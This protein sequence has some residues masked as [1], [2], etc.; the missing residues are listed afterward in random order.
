MRPKNGPLPAPWLVVGTALALAAAGPGVLRSRAALPGEPASLAGR[1]LVATEDLR[2]PRFDH[3]VVYMVRHDPTG[4][5]GLVVNRPLGQVP[6]ARLLELF[7]RSDP[8]VAGE[9]R[10]FYGGPVEGARAFVLHTT[11][12]TSPATLVVAGGVAL[13]AHPAVLEAIAH[14]RGPRRSLFAL[15]YAGWAPGQLEGEIRRGS[16]ISVPADE[17]L[18]FDDDADAKWRRAMARRR[19]AI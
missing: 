6:L 13:T 10:V 18:V 14:G 17:A 12:W 5:M 4:A 16:W 11:D 2:D 9:A 8:D 19:F 1:L 3:T 7:G 15:G